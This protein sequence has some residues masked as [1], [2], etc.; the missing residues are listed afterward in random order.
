MVRAAR[1]QVEV[2]E[3]DVW[4]LRSALNGWAS[5]QNPPNQHEV[6]LNSFCVSVSLLLV[7]PHDRSLI[8]DPSLHSPTHTHTHTRPRFVPLFCLVRRRRGINSSRRRLHRD[9]SRPVRIPP[10]QS[11][12]PAS[13]SSSARTG[14]PTS[15]HAACTCRQTPAVLSS[16]ARPPPSLISTRW[17]TSASKRA[18]ASGLR[19]LA[20]LSFDSWVRSSLGLH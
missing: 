6:S 18:D 8:V 3:A 15:P 20:V 5:E 9:E 17:P 4:R 13:R 19:S 11:T 10:D 14:C 12:P 7:S 1:S 16:L 2:L